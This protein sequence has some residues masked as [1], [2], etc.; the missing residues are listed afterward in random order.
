MSDSSNSVHLGSG[1]SPETV[2]D[3]LTS[4][5]SGWVDRIR[6]APPLDRRRLAGDFVIENP[7]LSAAWA[8]LGDHSVETIDRYAFYRVGYHRGLDSLRQSGW[9]GS[10]Y[11]RASH[12]GNLGFMRC[13]HGLAQAAESIGEHDEAQ[14]CMQFLGQLDP[15]WKAELLGT[16][17]YVPT[18][19]E[20]GE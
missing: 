11:V 9:R 20:A 13:L 4:A 12:P 6:S 14:R 16:G 2:L 3:P 10:G 7:R 19:T 1:P 8:E 5:Q 18:Q 17:G 15:R